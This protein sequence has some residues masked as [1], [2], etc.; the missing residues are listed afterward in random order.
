MKLRV[1]QRLTGYNP[2]TELLAVEYDIPAKAFAKVKKIARVGSDD[3]EAIGS[4]PLDRAQVQEVSTVI[5]SE[6]DTDRF[7]YF[8]ETFRDG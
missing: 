6:V 2:D 1:A 8:V 3:P 5:G 4:Y 7:D